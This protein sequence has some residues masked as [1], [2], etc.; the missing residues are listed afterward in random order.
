MERSVLDASRSFLAQPGVGACSSIACRTQTSAPTYASASIS[1]VNVLPTRRRS[2]AEIT[3]SC[4]ASSA[5]WVIVPR[6]E[7]EAPVTGLPVV[8]DEIEVG[9]HAASSPTGRAARVGGPRIHGLRK[10]RLTDA[11][12]GLRE[13]VR[14]VGMETLEL[15]G[16][17][18]AADTGVERRAVIGALGSSPQ[19]NDGSVAVAR[20]LVR[21][22]RVSS[23]SAA[24]AAL[25]RSTPPA[26]S[27]R[28][29]AAITC[30][31]VR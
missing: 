14:D 3:S 30:L 28:E 2:S 12:A 15:R 24:T 25:H 1:R 19:A 8:A 31:Q 21:D 29:T 7:L 6:G 9:D 26:A 22:R 23:G 27:R 18:R 4:A 16:V 11:I 5:A 20:W 13:R 10:D 17:P